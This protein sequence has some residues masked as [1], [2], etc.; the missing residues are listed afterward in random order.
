MA[1]PRKKTLAAV[2]LSVG[3]A[4]GTALAGHAV[5]LV[6]KATL[7][8]VLLEHAWD[9]T[10]DSGVPH[11]PWFWADTYPV[12]RL[13]APAHDVDQIVLA[14]SSGRTLAFGPAHVQGTA[15]P[16]DSGLSMMS[17][18]RDTHFAFLENL[19]AGDDLLIETIDTTHGYVVRDTL[20]IDL[21]HRQFAA[22]PMDDQLV[23]VTCYP[24]HRWTTGGSQ[25]Y[26]V[27]A[28]RVS[29]SSVK[30]S[31]HAKHPFARV[32]PVISSLPIP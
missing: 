14:G 15:R 4:M 12:A 9:R 27:I 18:H 23:L 25:R 29:A 1:G 30:G 32:E 19:R 22:D 24:F 11:Q 8:Q 16:G 5:Y 20:V 7:A 26:I 6:A 17:G 3:L 28:D 2:V 13:T 10:R 21:G 31:K